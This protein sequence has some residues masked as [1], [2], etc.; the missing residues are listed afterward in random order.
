MVLDIERVINSLGVHVTQTELIGCRAA[1]R[2]QQNGYLVLVEIRLDR[3][4]QLEAIEHEL[5]HILHGHFDNRA[6]L[7]EEIKELEACEP[8]LWKCDR[9]NQ[10]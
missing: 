9:L 7:P 6:D 4:S 3:L 2:K 10:K 5:L 1:T 8:W